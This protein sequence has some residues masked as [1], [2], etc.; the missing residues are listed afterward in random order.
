MVSPQQQLQ[1]EWITTIIASIS[2]LCSLCVIISF[3][4]FPKHLRQYYCRLIVYL[5]IFDFFWAI[6]IV[7]Q[8]AK[9][10]VG[11]PLN[12]VPVLCNLVG[13]FTNFLKLCQNIWNGF[14]AL[15]LLLA[16]VFQIST[17]KA[18]P[19]VMVFNILFSAL[20]TIL[21]GTIFQNGAAGAWC[22]EVNIVAQQALFYYVIYIVMIVILVSYIWMIRWIVQFRS[23]AFGD[24][25]V[26][27][28]KVVKKLA[29]YPLSFMIVW[30]PA[31][32]RR[33]YE[34]E[35]GFCYPLFILMGFTVPLEGVL[36]FLAF[37]RNQ[38]LA[39][40][41]HCKIMN[42]SQEESNSG[43]KGSVQSEN[44]SNANSAGL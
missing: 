3:L 8:T 33:A 37:A 11:I 12:A 25:G 13:I 2:W 22:F 23:S 24:I 30:V 31:I 29:F 14:I 4:V 41:W 34:A 44:H 15:T 1:V 9:A 27:H 36:N 42:K 39:H 32:L 19:Y 16:V 20:N 43:T 6:T 5:A 10:I 17:E 21:G 18:E 35:Y 7:P 28:R 40:R 26:M 38:R